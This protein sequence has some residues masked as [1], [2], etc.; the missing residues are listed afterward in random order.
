VH[1]SGNRGCM[2]VCVNLSGPILQIKHCNDKG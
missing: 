1:G 2:K